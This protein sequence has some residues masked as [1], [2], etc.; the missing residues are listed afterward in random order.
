MKKTPKIPHFKKVDDL[1]KHLKKKNIPFQEFEVKL[2]KKEHKKL[3]AFL[4]KK[5]AHEKKS[6][7]SKM[8]FGK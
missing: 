7:K 4:K 1:I 6:G 3:Q 8:K 5:R 2:D